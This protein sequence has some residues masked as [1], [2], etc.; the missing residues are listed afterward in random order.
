MRTAQDKETEKVCPHFSYN[1]LM[2]QWLI[3]ISIEQGVVST[4]FQPTPVTKATQFSQTSLLPHPT[5]CSQRSL[6]TVSLQLRQHVFHGLTE[7]LKTIKVCFYPE[8][9]QLLF[10]HALENL[11]M[12]FNAPKRFSVSTDKN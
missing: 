4:L 1:E 2:T 12:R 3:R 9:S 10:T 6:T 5:I 11:E 7:Q 8:L